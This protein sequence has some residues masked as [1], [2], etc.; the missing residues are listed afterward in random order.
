RF[1]RLS[2]H[3]ALL[4]DPAPGRDRLDIRRATALQLE[5]HGIA[6]ERIGLCPLCTMA[7]PALFHSWRRDGVRA[8]QWSGVVSQG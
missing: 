7:E 5:R 4:P 1:T 8:V 2:H 3:P 6:P